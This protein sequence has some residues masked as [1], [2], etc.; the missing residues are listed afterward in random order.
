[1]QTNLKPHLRAHAGFARSFAPGAL[2]LGVIA[3]FYG[4]DGAVPDI[5]EF[6]R[7]ARLSAALAGL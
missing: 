5:G 1:M 4:Y 2:R 7:A 3:P 6:V